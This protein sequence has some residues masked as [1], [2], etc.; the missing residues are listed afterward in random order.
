MLTY[1]FWITVGAIIAFV[2]WLRHGL[3]Q[4]RHLNLCVGFAL[5]VLVVTLAL[6]TREIYNLQ[7]YVSELEGM[8]TRLTRTTWE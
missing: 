6:A 1:T 7:A 4:S 5:L 8:V 3:A 2:W